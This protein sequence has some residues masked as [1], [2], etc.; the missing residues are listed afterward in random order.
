MCRDLRS[1]VIQD[2]AI[3]EGF[4]VAVNGESSGQEIN[5]AISDVLLYP[6]SVYPK[7][8]VHLTRTWV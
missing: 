6:M 3:P 7:F 2:V 5:V 1:V 8:T 4:C